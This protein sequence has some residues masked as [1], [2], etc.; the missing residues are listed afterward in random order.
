MNVSSTW[1]P[2][3]QNLLTE[4]PIINERHLITNV[5]LNNADLYTIKVRAGAIEKRIRYS[6]IICTHEECKN[7]FINNND[8][9]EGEFFETKNSTANKKHCTNL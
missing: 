6:K 3:N 7:I 9:I 2:T 1:H 5:E 8:K 4:L